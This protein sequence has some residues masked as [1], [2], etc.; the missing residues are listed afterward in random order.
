MFTQNS[1]PKSMER[2]CGKKYKILCSIIRT[3]WLPVHLL[4]MVILQDN[5]PE[6]K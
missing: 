1:A 3:R 2:H 4:N 6:V 5:A